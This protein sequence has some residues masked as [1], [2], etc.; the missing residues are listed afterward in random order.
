MKK[1][2]KAEK[3]YIEQ[4]VGAMDARDIAADLDLDVRT[5][6]AYLKSLP[7][8]SPAPEP[9]Q[10]ARPKL[11]HGFMR[12]KNGAVAMTEEQGQIDDENK[13]N[14][15]YLSRHSKNIHIIDPTRPVR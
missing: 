10:E 8:A 5:V 7:A 1:L 9:P 12:H 14:R 15:K 6:R 11:D 3:F 13:P 4:H 2:S